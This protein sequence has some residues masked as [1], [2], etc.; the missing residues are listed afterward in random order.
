MLD[1]A[2]LSDCLES[3]GLSNWATALGPLLEERL[4][5]KSHGDYLSWRN[6]VEALADAGSDTNRLE[7]LLLELSPWRKGPWEVG[8]VSIDS[9]WRSDVKWARLGNAIAPLA[10]RCVLDVGCGN[11]YYA[12]QMREAGARVV[13]GVDPTLLFVMQFFAV[14]SFKHDPAVFVLPVRLHE[15]PLPVHKFDTT[16]SMGVLYHQR[17]PLAHLQQLRTT[18]RPGGQLVLETIYMPGD[19]SFTFTP[20]ARYARMRNVWSLPGITE[21]T[22]WMRRSGYQDIEVIDKSITTTNE[23]R[24]TKW[25]RFQSLHEAL[26]PDDANRTVEGW[27]A[28]HRVAV[29]AINP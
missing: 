12:F 29:T 24:S 9:E 1:H 13:I 18:L 20:G 8:G 26:D 17:S 15:L 16:F 19:E 22:T 10:D 6:V 2:A 5:D 23:Q 28:P 14:N 11:G 7:K 4:S 3:I 21:L 25:M 27:P